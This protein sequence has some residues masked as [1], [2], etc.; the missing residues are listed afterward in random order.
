MFVKDGFPL[1]IFG[2]CGNLGQ[3][4]QLIARE[5]SKELNVAERF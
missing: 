5:A 2:L 1:A 3:S 4:S